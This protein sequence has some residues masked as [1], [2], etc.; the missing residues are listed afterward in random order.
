M[1]AKTHSNR[2]FEFSFP[3]VNTLLLV[4]DAEDKVN[5]PEISPGFWTGCVAGKSFPTE[6]QE[7]VIGVAI[8]D[9]ILNRSP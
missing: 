8:R 7:A 5:H 9:V 2:S 6:R 4:E 1:K 3:D